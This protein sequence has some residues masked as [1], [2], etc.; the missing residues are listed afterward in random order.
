MP[1]PSSGRPPSV[2]GSAT[3]L[4]VRRVI[5][6]LTALL[7]VAV[8][9]GLVG[10]LAAPA[11]SAAVAVPLTLSSSGPS[12]VTA[13][14]TITYTLTVKNPTG[15]LVTDVEL[16][17]PL[18]TNSTFVSGGVVTDGVEQTIAAVSANGSASASFV[19]R[20]EPGT[21]VGTRIGADA[22]QIYQYTVDGETLSPAEGIFSPDAFVTTVEAPGTTTASYKNGDGRAFDVATDG[23]GFQNYG[24]DPPRN[25]AD[26][27]GVLDVFELF[28]PVACKSGTTAATCVLTG[29]AK[30]WL[31]AAIANMSGGHCDGLAATSVR[32]FEGLPFRG[33]AGTPATFEPGAATTNQL[34][35]SQPEE[36]YI[37][38]Y[39]Q[40]QSLS[41]TFEAAEYL[42]PNAMVARLTTDFNAVPSVPYT[43]GFYQPGFKDGHSVTPIGVERV[44]DAESRIL[45]YD[46]NF[47][48]QRQYITVDTLA[49]SWRYVTASDPRAPATVY[50]GD[51]STG[52][53]ELNPAA[54]REL[55]PGQYF[56]APFAPAATDAS[57][58]QKGSTGV[59][60][61]EAP[62][63][64]DPTLTVK[65]AGEGSMLITDDQGRASGDDPD[66]SVRDEIPG[67]TLDYNTGG[68]DRPIPPVVTIPV[69]LSNDD[70]DYT[71]S[72][73]GV[74][75][76]DSTM[77]SLSISGPGYTIGVNDVDLQPGEVFDFS[78][79]PNGT[80]IA[81]T[82]SEPSTIAPAIFI[83][84]DPVDEGDASLVFTLSN[85]II[86]NGE[87][88]FL[89]LDP[90]LQLVAFEDTS[91]LGQAADVDME[92]IFPDG[93]SDLFSQ[94]IDLDEGNTTAFV[95]FGAWDGLKDPAVFIDDV[96]QNPG[97]NHR[98]TLTG[99][100][101]TYDPTP[102]A[103]APAGV[104]TVTATFQDVTEV[105]L[106]DVY[107][108][109]ADLGAGNVVLDAE[110]GPSGTGAEIAVPAEALGED[111]VLAAN[112]TFTATFRVG[113][114]TA[115]DSTITLDANGTPFDWAQV[116]PEPA[117]DAT[118][119]SYVLAVSGSS[120]GAPPVTP[121]PGAGPG[122][123][124]GAGPG[125]A[126]GA[127]PGAAPAAPVGGTPGAGPGGSA[128]GS[129]LAFTGAAGLIPL[130]VIGI[131]LV[132]LGGGAVHAAR[133]R[134][135]QA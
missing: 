27:L 35:L 30:T 86:D 42:D 120:A 19:V 126:P 81:Y 85:V 10:V 43:M 52:T 37:A 51:A 87:R 69:D 111:G 129:P 102:A 60:A 39:F 46:N 44:S 97:A 115:T 90:A 17:T 113:L 112:G 24:N 117:Y 76:Q 125:A 8:S 16:F 94:P 108:T 77:G 4:T 101:T 93:S 20:V 6:A 55:P 7:M 63:D 72:L 32:L 66:G 53:L 133:R 78:F 11:A 84:Y 122:A 45:I 98:L 89:D 31:Q 104:N 9:S 22:P 83:A 25:S 57:A 67:D 107:F 56:Q 109:V 80:N 61:A 135:V 21:P 119:T 34:T 18:P 59:A 131:V 82:S 5:S 26:D 48:N 38:R 74:T 127:G 28:G 14:D 29:P 41:P 58:L 116:D 100:T 88:V 114:A 128:S 110:G 75:D 71:V 130:T 47:P 23:Y 106:S 50:A 68:L 92:M 33:T 79:R 95:D 15:R 96:L 118:D 99:S 12:Y 65:Y 49:N 121:A 124:P 103:G 91:A 73:R 54:A 70:V 123:A 132:L 105:S 13:G 3:G 62:L 36:N 40:T 1:G 134:R 64:D 2:A